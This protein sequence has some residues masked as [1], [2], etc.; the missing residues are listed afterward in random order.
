MRRKYETEQRKDGVEVKR[1]RTRKTVHKQMINANV[2]VETVEDLN[3]VTYLEDVSLFNH[4][5]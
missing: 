1:T 4:F 3:T 5:N 2:K